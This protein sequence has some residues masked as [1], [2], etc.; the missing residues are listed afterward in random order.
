MI[1][2]GGELSRDRLNG[3]FGHLLTMS[4]MSLVI[5]AALVGLNVDLRTLLL[6]DDFRSHLSAG[7][8]G[9]ADRRTAVT[10]TDE[11]NAIEN[12]LGARLPFVSI[13]IDLLTLFHEV[14]T[15][16]IINDRKHDPALS[17]PNWAQ[18]WSDNEFRIAVVRTAGPVSS[19][20]CRLVVG[21][22]P[23]TATSDGR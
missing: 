15:A 19:K 10:T 18:Q 17:A 16:S 13:D 3:D 20:D 23:K 14:L 7:D 22:V 4:D 8:D 21:A 1:K 6:S 5:L 9:L 2:C 11:K 12:D